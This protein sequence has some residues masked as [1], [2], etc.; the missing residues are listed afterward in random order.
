[1]VIFTAL[2]ED[3]ALTTPPDALLVRGPGLGAARVIWKRAVL[4]RMYYMAVFSNR[5]VELVITHKW[6]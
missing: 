6:R 2:Q 3:F 5:R 1:L 4:E